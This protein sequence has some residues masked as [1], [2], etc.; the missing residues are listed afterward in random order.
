MNPTLHRNTK[1]AGT[2]LEADRL[3]RAR[4]GNPKPR[5]D[6]PL[7]A[8]VR[9]ILSQ[10]TSDVNSRQ[11]YEALR[12]AFPAWQNVL[13]ADIADVEAAL[14][15]GGLAK[16]KSRCIVRMLRS[17]AARG[18][19]NLDY[20]AELPTPEAEQAL[21]A[22]DGV[23]PK[24]ASCVLLF[25]LGRDVFPIDTHIARILK[26]LGVVS[27]GMPV[28]TAHRYVAPLAP[29]GRSLALHVNLIAHGRGVCRARR[30]DCAACVLR[31]L[32]AY[33]MNAA[34]APVEGQA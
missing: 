5:R 12:R 27:E 3:L 34:A 11:A 30:P 7:E 16:T 6:N 9:T 22:F 33:A 15:P 20:L 19:L 23:G 1:D 8:L 4:Y 13:D 14:R 25:A 17:V 32:C 31:P 26:R 2:L 10:N 18:A 28:E 29:P 24:T 21:M